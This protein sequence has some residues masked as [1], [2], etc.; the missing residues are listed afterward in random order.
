MG[1]RDDA[2]LDK[3]APLSA[4]D[5]GEMRR[6]KA[7]D[8]AARRVSLLFHHR[9]GVEVV[10]FGEGQSLTVGRAHPADLVLPDESLSRQHATLELLD[11]EL[12]VE[13][14]GSTNGTRVDSVTVERARV[15][16]EAELFLGAVSVVVHPLG[17]DDGLSA[18]LESH[19]RFQRTLVAELARAS[20]FRRSL[21]LLLLRGSRGRGAKISRWWPAARRLVRA[22]DVAA[23]YSDDTVEL[24]LP[25]VGPADAA[26]R[27]QALV[28]LEPTLVCGVGV[29]PDQATSAEAL[30]EVSRS[31][32]Q[33]ANDVTRV[34]VATAAIASD[35][36]SPAGPVVASPAMVRV[37]ETALRCGVMTVP[38]LIQGETGT[39]K[40]IVA[41]AIHDSGPRKDKPLICINCGAIPDQLVES[42][43]FGHE[44]GAFT[45]AHQQSQGVFESAHRGTV[46][47]DE[48]GE[49]SLQ[50]QAALLRVLETK[51]FCRVGS[52]KEVQVDVRV[53]AATHRDLEQMRS[54]GEFREDLFYRLDAMAVFIPPLRERIDEIEPLIDRFIEDANRANGRAVDGVDPEA[55]AL[56]RE[57][58]W[59]G[60]VRELRNAIER[61]VAIARG[62]LITPV[63]L[64]ARVAQLARSGRTPDPVELA[65]T[66]A[67]RKSSLDLRSEVQRL[68]TDLIV[69]ALRRAGGNRTRAANDLGMAV[70]TLFYKMKQYGITG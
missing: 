29:F 26:A 21:T 33:R 56:L 43:F 63:D 41:R 67:P 27:A 5:L 65:D 10:P 58:R 17:D 70:R 61:A 35:A 44:R 20:Q 14:L 49:L 23:L 2:S 12:W 11:G 8:S 13:D 30:L 24:L 34:K 55:V 57:Y 18:G 42:T 51:R 4:S 60:N 15:P 32:L 45:G 9:H 31:A 47:L 7:K 36:A 28:A 22:F 53:I 50:A 1:S 64:P 40:E 52:T 19:D 66:P 39:G 68:E 48:I 62:A 37:F 54:R 59:P 46:F 25:E 69:D 6:I 3:T 38:V 16:L